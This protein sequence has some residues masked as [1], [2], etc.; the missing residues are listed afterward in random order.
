MSGRARSWARTA[1]VMGFALALRLVAFGAASSLSPAAMMAP[2]SYGYDQLARTLLHHG[3]F[4]E[5]AEGAAQTRRTPGY[6]LLLAGVYAL[7]GADDRRLAVLVGIAI[8]TATV[9]LCARL[10]E[11][12]WG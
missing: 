10:A 1:A 3:R 11:R 12:L 2:D 5:N 6:P 9:G 4:A 7:A 8:S